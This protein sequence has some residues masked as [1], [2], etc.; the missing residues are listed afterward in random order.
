[1]LQS[2]AIDI[3]LVPVASIPSIA[4]AKLIS[5]YCIGATGAVASVCLYS[6]VPVDQI[7][8]VLLDYQ[9]ESSVA[10]VKLLLHNYWNRQVDYWPAAPGYENAIEG[11]VAGVII[12]D[13]ALE[14]RRFFPY[15][16]DLAEAWVALTGLPFVFAAWVATK[17][18]TD[19]F[20]TQFNSANQFGLSRI[21]EV[22]AENPFPFYDVKKYFTENIS[23]SFDAAKQNG[24]AEFLRLLEAYKN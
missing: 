7:N 15:C 20:V 4:Q 12:G 18:L 21:D 6:H 24:L 22:V 8:T 2:G 23:Y 14:Y 16:Y 10:L 1:M 3:G 19:G 13:R 11:K 5:D 9:S 17:P